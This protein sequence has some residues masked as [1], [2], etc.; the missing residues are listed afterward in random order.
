MDL[1][2]ER[3][4]ALDVA[5]AEVVAAIRVPGPSGG[6]RC[7]IRTY[8]AFSG[9]LAAMA[10]WFASEGV[11]QVVMESTGQY[12]KPVWFVLAEAGFEL[13]LVNARHVKMVPGRKTDVA[14]AA[15]LAELAEHG[16]LRGSFVPPEAIARLRD[17]TRYR[18][19]LIQ[20]AAQEHQRV[21]KVLE[22]AGI[23]LDVVASDLFGASGRAMLR[24][25]VDGERDPEVLAE[26]AKGVLRKKMPALRAALAGH[27]GEHHALL[28]GIAL[29]HIETLA[30]AVARLDA[31]VEAELAPFAEALAHL[32]TIPG[33]GRRTAEEIVA[34][35]GADMSVFPTPAHLAS[36]AGMCPGNNSS[37]GKRR[38]GRTRQGN[39][40][41]KAALTEAAWAASH[42]RDTYLA[43][44]F[45]RLA[46]RIGR[47]RAAI[48][49]GHSIL[50]IAWHL[51]S[52]DC[53]YRDLG[54][55]YFVTRDAEHSRRRAVHQLEALGFKVNLEPSAA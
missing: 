19:R 27:F 53:D 44:Q 17:L 55:D 23:K 52:E 38:S 39:A 30:A 32:D 40:W 11:T 13:A 3:V 29:D 22:D 9:S 47:K 8:S 26:M 20:T 24:A 18:R 5:K 41:L 16:L 28:V 54:G 4:A 42:A 43:A 7:E 10:D 45:W 25:L 46:R 35:T 31:Q 51:L 14:D 49:V 1:T 21:E 36:W 12:W 50:V 6:R 34:E 33:V 2:V 37:A 15:W 48:A